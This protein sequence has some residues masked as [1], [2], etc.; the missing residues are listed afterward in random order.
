MNESWPVSRLMPLP[1]P[2]RSLAT[3]PVSVELANKQWLD[4]SCFA[5]DNFL[6]L[7]F[8]NISWQIFARVYKKNM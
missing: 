2:W 1:R 7:H 5:S 8:K 4:I 3:P 6:N